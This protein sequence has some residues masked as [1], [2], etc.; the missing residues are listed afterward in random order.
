VSALGRSGALGLALLVAA[1]AFA[2]GAIPAQLERLQTLRARLEAP[3]VRPAAAARA[4]ASPEEQM[5]AFYAYFPPLATLPDWLERIYGAAA[6]RGLALEAGEYRL[7]PQ[8]GSRLA[9]YQV[10]L[11]VHGRYG[12]V[13][14][15]IAEVLAQVPPAALE[16]VSFRRESIGEDAL[17]VRLRF[18]L[19]LQRSM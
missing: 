7:A 5:Q 15:F 18:T 9:R 19:Y 6:R 16:E 2:M 8:P 1:A 10:T 14:A 11:P 4:P 17:H 3:Q 13:R 12:Q